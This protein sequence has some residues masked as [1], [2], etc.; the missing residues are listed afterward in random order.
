MKG[1]APSALHRKSAAIMDHVVSMSKPMRMLVHEY[2]YVIVSA[3]IDDG[4]NDPFELFD[5]LDTWRSRRQEEWLNTNFKLAR[6]PSRR[7]E[8]RSSYGCG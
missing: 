8:A 3:M 4:Y 5:L 6:N 7:N 2:G 1:D